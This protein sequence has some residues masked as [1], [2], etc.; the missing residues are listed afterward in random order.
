MKGNLLLSEKC[1]SWLPR[2]L[3]ANFVSS[4][5]CPGQGF[6]HQHPVGV[7]MLEN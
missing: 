5:V 7:L 4:G 3:L 2:T 1:V 6:Q